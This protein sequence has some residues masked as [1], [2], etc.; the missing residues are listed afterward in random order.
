MKAQ[1]KTLLH[2]LEKLKLKKALSQKEKKRKRDEE[3]EED[4]T[5]EKEDPSI[6]DGEK[7]FLRSR[8]SKLHYLEI[9]RE[10]E[11]IKGL[12]PALLLPMMVEW[13]LAC[14]LK[15]KK[16]RNINGIVTRQMRECLIKVYCTIGEMQKRKKN[17]E[18]ERLSKQLDEMKKKM[19]EIQEEN[20]NLRKELELVKNKFSTPC[21]SDL[22]KNGNSQMSKSLEKEPRKEK[23]K[24]GKN[25]RNIGS[26]KRNS[27]PSI[28][29]LERRGKNPKIRRELSYPL[30]ARG[31]DLGRKM[32]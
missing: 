31:S 4:E 21:S 28:T 5:E 8:S 22:L 30:D 9:V 26:I 14:E 13:V 17:T 7:I 27:Q 25:G 19:Q 11:Y 6:E 1:R 29:P 12:P 2:R 18:A 24:E 16:S 20:R 10:M 15:R 3:G 32:P 23:K